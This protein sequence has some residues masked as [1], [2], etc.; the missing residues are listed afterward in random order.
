[1]QKRKEMTE[2]T[3]KQKHFAKEIATRLRI[4]M[5]TENTS[6]AYWKFI[7]DHVKEFN[8][9]KRYDF[10]SAYEEDFEDVYSF[11]DLC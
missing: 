7:N 2:P 4:D 5:P 10:Y 1:M 3:R 6:Y 8:K 11:S 9:K